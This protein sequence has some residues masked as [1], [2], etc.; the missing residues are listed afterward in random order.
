MNNNNNKWEKDPFIWFRE[1]L[2]LL[3]LVEVARQ[4][5]I[6]VFC[7]I[8]ILAYNWFLVVRTTYIITYCIYFKWSAFVFYAR[9]LG[10]LIGKS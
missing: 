3:L 8:R 2:S 5:N 1:N 7:R 10:S 4:V 6:D 9:A